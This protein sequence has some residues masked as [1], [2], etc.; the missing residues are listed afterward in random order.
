MDVAFYLTQVERC[1][2]M[3][4]SAQDL[5]VKADLLAL[6]HDNLASARSYEVHRPQPLHPPA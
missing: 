3:A 4:K 6:A 2:R 1:L 5:D